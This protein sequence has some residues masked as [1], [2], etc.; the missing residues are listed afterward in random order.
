MKRQLAVGAV[1]VAAMAMRSLLELNDPNSLCL[2]GNVESRE[3]E[4][5]FGRW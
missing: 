3:L 5:H 1:G 2:V 4:E